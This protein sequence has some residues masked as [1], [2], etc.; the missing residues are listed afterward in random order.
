MVL[1]PPNTFLIVPRIHPSGLRFWAAMDIGRLLPCRTRIPPALSAIAIRTSIRCCRLCLPKTCGTNTAHFRIF[2][3]S[4]FLRKILRC[5]RGP[6]GTS[7]TCS[8]SSRSP[9]THISVLPVPSSPTL[10][11]K[12]NSR[13]VAIAWPSRCSP[14]ALFG[15]ALFSFSCCAREVY[16]FNGTRSRPALSRFFFGARFRSSWP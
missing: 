10:N 16:K 11:R 13:E 14:S 12:R 6:H 1:L 4:E 15:S 9:F 2:A 7:L 3:K 5:I 8:V